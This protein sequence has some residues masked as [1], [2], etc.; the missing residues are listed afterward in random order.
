MQV[1]LTRSSDKK[2]YTITNDHSA[3]SY[4]IPVVLDD[5]GNL[6]DFSA[7]LQEQYEEQARATG[8][9]DDIPGLPVAPLAVEA[10][11]RAAG[12][13]G[14]YTGL[15]VAADFANDATAEKMVECAYRGRAI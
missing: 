12:I 13:G 8:A 15:R 5:A 7:R 11:R 14:L 6:V 2:S 4:G 3:S 1:T 10:A 9:Y